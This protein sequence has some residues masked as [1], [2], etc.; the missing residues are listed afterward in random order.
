MVDWPRPL[1]EPIGFT[2]S[3]R[4]PSRV[5]SER[6]TTRCGSAGTVTGSWFTSSITR[7]GVPSA[8]PGMSFA[9]PSPA[10]GLLGWTLGDSLGAACVTCVVGVAPQPASS[11]SM[12]PA[13]T[14]PT[15]DRLR[16]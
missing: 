8:R 15:H 4:A 14:A 5:G 7:T 9:N 13:S 3:A 16:P 12:S 10:A 2:P 11:A 6:V 1:T